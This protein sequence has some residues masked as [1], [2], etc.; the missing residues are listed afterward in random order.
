M[1]FLA[2]VALASWYLCDESR[3]SHRRGGRPSASPAVYCCLPALEGATYRAFDG[4][5][6]TLRQVPPGGPRASMHIVLKPSCDALT[7][8]T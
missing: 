3:L 4:M 1:P 2:K 6:P 5:Q 7:A 8:A